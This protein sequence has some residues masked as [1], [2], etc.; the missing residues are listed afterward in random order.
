MTLRYVLKR[1]AR[2]PWTSLAT[3]GLA[4]ALCVLLSLLAATKA[5]QEQALDM[6]YDDMEIRCAVASA[7]GVR[8]EGLRLIGAMERLVYDAYDLADYVERLN[9][10]TT[11]VVRL[12]RMDIDVGDLPTLSAVTGLDAAPELRPEYGVSF[13]F[14]P[15]YGWEDMQSAEPVLVVSEAIMDKCW[16]ELGDQYKLSLRYALY[17]PDSLKLSEEMRPF[18]VIGCIRGMAAE[19]A[20]CP[21]AYLQQAAVAEG[22]Y[23]YSESASFILKDNRKLEEFRAAS[24]ACFD[25]PDATASHSAYGPFSLVIQDKLFL[26]TV[27]GLTRDI[28]LCE[29]LTPAVCVLCLGVGLCSGL[30]GVRAR[31]GKLVL[32]RCAGT[33]RRKAFALM[34]LEQA[35]LGTLGALVGACAALAAGYGPSAFA[36]AGVCAACFAAGAAVVAALFD[37]QSVMALVQAKE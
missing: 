23:L 25:A 14:L 28:R 26:E 8:T 2:T 11:F 9:L 12:G 33:P 21:F 16:L 29:A 36:A 37:S 31:R 18:L 13:E 22:Q 3:L 7:D 30:I 24:L 19:A 10:K 35:L 20:Y 1:I 4:A 15:G 6:A 27:K 32:M 5:K 34:L 17:F